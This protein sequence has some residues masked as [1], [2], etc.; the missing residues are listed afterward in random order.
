MDPFLQAAHQR[1]SADTGTPKSKPKPKPDTGAYTLKHEQEEEK[2]RQD[3]ENV[4]KLKQQR[5]AAKAAPPKFEAAKKRSGEVAT[6]QGEVSETQQAL[7]KAKEEGSGVRYAQMRYDDAKDKLAKK[8]SRDPLQEY[9][10]EPEP[11]FGSDH[12]AAILARRYGAAAIPAGLG[13]IANLVEQ[14]SLKGAPVV[15]KKGAELGVPFLEEGYLGRG[16]QGFSRQ[17]AGEPRPYPTS[18]AFAPGL[19]EGL[20]VEQHAAALERVSEAQEKAHQ[21]VA[22][23]KRLKDQLE[24]EAK[25]IAPDPTHPGRS[26]SIGNI[27]SGWTPSGAAEIAAARREL[28]KVEAE[29]KRKEDY[30][31][32]LNRIKQE[33]LQGSHKTPKAEG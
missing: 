1:K 31:E 11:P 10:V 24:K 14:A 3:L 5:D 12:P 6:L 4:Q 2:K 32:Q 22:M 29:L 17:Y 28:R 18:S 25:Y 15:E 30:L 8:T 20:T 27:A 13:V 23:Q 7:T 33:T 19:P 26:Y 16:G 21:D 9:G